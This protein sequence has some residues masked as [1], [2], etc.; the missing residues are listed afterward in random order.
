MLRKPG[1]RLKEHL[2]ILNSSFLSLLLIRLWQKDRLPQISYSL[3]KAQLGSKIILC[4]HVACGFLYSSLS[5]FLFTKV[6]NKLYIFGSLRKSLYVLILFLHIHENLTGTWFM[7]FT[8]AWKWFRSLC[9]NLQPTCKLSFS[10]ISSM[11]I[12]L[13]QCLHGWIQPP[14]N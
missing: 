10:S 3:F 14:S 8:A 9:T 11:M 4:E 2:D 1:G 12:G 6:H 5:V 7:C 13:E